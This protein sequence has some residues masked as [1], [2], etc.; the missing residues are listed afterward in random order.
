MTLVSGVSFVVAVSCRRRRGGEGLLSF[1]ALPS[2]PH[3]APSYSRPPRQSPRCIATAP[4]QLR[5][6]ALGFA[7]DSPLYSSTLHMRVR[8]ARTSWVTSL[9]ILAFCLDGSVWNHLA[10]RTL[11]G[12][13]RGW[14]GD[15]GEEEEEAR[16][17][18]CSEGLARAERAEPAP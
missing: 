3:P 11:P 8:R 15:G 1:A 5:L 13:E 4:S 18:G 6:A 12:C 16:K 10:R 7:R 17:P 9:T 2:A 14:G